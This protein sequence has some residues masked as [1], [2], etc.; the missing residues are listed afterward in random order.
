MQRT[1][2][3]QTELLLSHE[4][5]RAQWSQSKS[6]LVHQ[7]EDLKNE[8]DRMKIKCD[9]YYKETVNLRNEVKNLRQNPGGRY[10]PGAGMSGGMQKR[11][12]DGGF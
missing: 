6:D 4:R 8:F 5:E 7:K 11:L 2:T 10:Q 9:N 3:K 1:E 12:I